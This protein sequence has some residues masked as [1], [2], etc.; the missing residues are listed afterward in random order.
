MEMR[1][2]QLGRKIRE[3]EIGIERKRQEETEKKR[4]KE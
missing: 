4:H 1:K 2:E 3:E